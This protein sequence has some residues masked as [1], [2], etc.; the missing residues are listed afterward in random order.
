M[1]VV[2]VLGIGLLDWEV[3]G[4][5]LL[6]FML[7]VGIICIGVFLFWMHSCFFWCLS[8]IGGDICC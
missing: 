7:K 5:I 1:V 3:V 2:F 4:F 8:L 6:S